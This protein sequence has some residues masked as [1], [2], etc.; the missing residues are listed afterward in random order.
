MTGSIDKYA[1][2]GSSKPRWRYRI[3]TGK[4]DAGAKR[5]VSGA[6]FEKQGEA[7]DAMRTKIEELL[8]LANQPAPLEA[9]TLTA[10]LKRWLDSYAVHTCQPKT[11]ERYGQLVRY[12]TASPTEEVQRI[13]AAPI[14]ALKHVNMESAL[15][16][17]LKQKAAK[18]EHLSARSVRHVAGVL[19]VA[20]NEA[21]RLDLILVNP[22]LK[23]KL[24]SVERSRAES[25]TPEQ[26]RALRA[27]CRGDW[28]FTLIELALATGARRG[29]ML[30]LTWANVDWVTMSITIA[31]SLE[32]TAAGLRIKMP[33][34]EKERPCSLPQ[35]A[36]AALQFQRE[37][38]AEHKRKFGTDYV[39]RDLVFAQPNGDFL[40][41]A[42]V[43]QIV[44][45]RMRKA[46]IKSGS[47]HSLRHTMASVLLSN[48]VPLP[49][50]SARLGHADANITARIYSHALPDDDRR[51]ADAWDTV[52]SNPVQ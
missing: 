47:F 16:A 7:A 9:I 12:I 17:L 46:G 37:E 34:N 29:E 32:Q 41:P 50:V 3:Y 15:R 35:T 39:E 40:D 38:Q 24:P 42:L 31:R 45:R 49:A 27:S 30:A 48:G 8:R 10:W 21:F 25:F 19:Q 20:L 4:D 6:G 2:K 33:K 13:A 36:I 23:V 44:I 5:Y 52:I 26:V 14:S 11:L 1:V 51:A 22:M 28:T 18:R 43:S